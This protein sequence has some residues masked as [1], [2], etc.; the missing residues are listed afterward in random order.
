MSMYKITVDFLIGGFQ[1]LLVEAKDEEEAKTK[2]KSYFKSD[3]IAWE[4]DEYDNSDVCDAW[5]EDIE[6]VEFDK[7]GVIHFYG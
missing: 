1:I 2:K 6:I 4:T 3:N 7:F 5:F